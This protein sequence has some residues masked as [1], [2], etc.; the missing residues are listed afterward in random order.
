MKITCITMDK[1]KQGRTNRDR[2]KI[3]PF[4]N[5]PHIFQYFYSKILA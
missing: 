1:I 4:F 5:F 3:D 2:T